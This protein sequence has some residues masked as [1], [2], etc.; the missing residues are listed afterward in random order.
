MDISMLVL[1]GKFDEHSFIFCGI[2]YVILKGKLTFFQSRGCAIFSRWDQCPILCNIL[3]TLAEGNQDLSLRTTRRP[4]RLRR[5]RLWQNDQCSDN[6]FLL[7]LAFPATRRR[8]LSTNL[9]IARRL[10]VL[11]PWLRRSHWSNRLWLFI[12]AKIYP[13]MNRCK[14]N[15][16]PKKFFI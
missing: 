12:N 2:L 3:H 11:L 10:D 8:R 6:P 16:L 15:L 9:A 14:K 7:P 1:N 5:I 13:F 4:C